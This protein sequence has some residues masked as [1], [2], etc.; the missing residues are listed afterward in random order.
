MHTTT[1]KKIMVHELF[2]TPVLFLDILE[3]SKAEEAGAEL[4]WLG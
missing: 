4:E 1:Y 2:P 3:H